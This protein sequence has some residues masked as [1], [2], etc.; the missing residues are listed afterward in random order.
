M[1]SR[2]IALALALLLCST[3]VAVAAPPADDPVVY[4]AFTN[5][6]ELTDGFIS[7]TNKI[8]QARAKF[9]RLGTRNPRRPF[10]SH[11]HRRQLSL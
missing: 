2:L 11:H 9:K 7:S 4:P 10:R 3:N 8:R 6:P 5:V 1:L